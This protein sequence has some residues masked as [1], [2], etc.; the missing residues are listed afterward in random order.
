[1]VVVAVVVA[2]VVTVV[3][4]GAAVGDAEGT[5]VGLADGTDVGLADGAPVGEAVGAAVGADVG[6]KLLFDKYA[7]TVEYDEMTAHVIGTLRILL[8]TPTHVDTGIAMGAKMSDTVVSVLVL[9]VSV[10]TGV[11]RPSSTAPAVSELS[12]RTNT[13]AID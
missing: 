7:S 1:M 12:C 8:I 2:V 6:L 11:D 4:A 13:P 10:P 5:A 9:T 3:E